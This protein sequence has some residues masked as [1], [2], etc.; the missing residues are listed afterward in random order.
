MNR[1]R[2]LGIG[3][4]ALGF[5]GLGAWL[6]SRR[7]ALQGADSVAIDLL[8][9]LELPD[10]SGQPVALAALRGRPTLVNFWATWCPPCVEEMPELSRFDAE[11][12]PR[13]L[14]IV[15]IGIDNAENIRQF[16][17]KSSIS[18]PLLV[19]GGNGLELIRRL[20]NTAGALPFSVLIDPD[21]RVAWRTLGRFDGAELRAAILRL[22]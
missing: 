5:G 13:G 2:W 12:H 11:F 3:V 18:Y 15:G 22:V 10:A 20:G 19:A 1:R 6:A 17:E 7:Y 21:G 9:K 8:F 14:R 4:V 16:S